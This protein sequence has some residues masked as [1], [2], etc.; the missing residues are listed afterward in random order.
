M[1]APEEPLDAIAVEV[2]TQAEDAD[3]LALVGG[4][5]DPPQDSGRP[6][7]VAP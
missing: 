3:P 5:A 1:S 2:T 7:G 4:P 6:E